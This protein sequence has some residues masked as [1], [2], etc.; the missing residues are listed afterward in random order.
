M[1]PDFH[2][3]LMQARVTDLRHHAHRDALARAVGQARPARTPP[4]GRAVA[5]L[6]AATRRM[7]AVLGARS[8]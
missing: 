1:R 6:P 7:L 8:T 5:R 2:Y 4:S 3:E